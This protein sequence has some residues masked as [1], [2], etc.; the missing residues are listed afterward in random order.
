MRTRFFHSFRASLCASAVLLT[1]CG[2]GTSGASSSQVA[3]RVG[4]Q[5]ISQQ[6]FTLRLTHALTTVQQAG[7]PAS[8]RSS[9]AVAMTSALRARVMRGLIIDAVIAQEAQFRHVAAS[10]SDVS[11]EVNTAVKAAGGMSALQQQLSEAGGS[12]DQLKDEIRSRLNEQN[13]QDVFAKQRADM[14]MAQLQSGAA[15]DAVAKSIS[16][17]DNSRSNGGNLGTVTDDQLKTDDQAFAQTVRSLHAGQTSSPVRDDSGYDILR[18]TAATIG[19][20]TVSRIL[21]AAP[22][23]YTVT[24]APA[25]FSESTFAAVSQLC[26]RNEIHVYIDAGQQPCSALSASPSATPS[27]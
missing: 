12:I 5:T 3:A 18:V 8:P 4:T 17:D 20:R 23:P 10:D 13:L 7:A 25:W 1:A 11:N 14:A 19:S 27:T 9:P 16:D 15:F 6:L 2:A 21:I 22:R 26:T 24:N